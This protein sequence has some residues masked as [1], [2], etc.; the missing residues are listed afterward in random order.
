MVQERIPGVSQ[1]EWDALPTAVR[2]YIEL[3]DREIAELKA[4]VES[5]EAQL[6][7]NSGNS[8]KP[9]ASDEFHKTP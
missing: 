1:Q 4:R 3:R 7:K 5:L 9:P 2:V 6:A 8:H